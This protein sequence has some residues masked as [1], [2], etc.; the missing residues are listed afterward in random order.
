M[1]KPIALPVAQQPAQV[2]IWVDGQPIAARAG[3]TLATALLT[4][5]REPFRHT[6]VS[7]APRM[8]FCLMGA[9]FEC[10]VEVDG[11]PN[12]Q[13]CMVQVRPGMKVRRMHGAREAEVRA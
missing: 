10:L 1:F 8:P 11:Q 4:Q 12:V 6:A 9:C 7:G 3:E 13:A 5:A 2:Q